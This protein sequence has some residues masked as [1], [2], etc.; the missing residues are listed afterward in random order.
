MKNIRFNQNII[1]QL[2]ELDAVEKITPKMVCFTKQFK[3]SAVELKNQGYS[4]EQ[5]FT[6]AGIDVSI[7]KKDH[8]Q[9]LLKKWARAIRKNSKNAF[10][11]KPKGPKKN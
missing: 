1:N 3:F 7:F 2:S 4:T 10:I 9:H 8:F 11:L 5:I 6:D